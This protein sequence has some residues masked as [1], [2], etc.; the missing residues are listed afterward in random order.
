MNNNLKNATQEIK[1]I[2][3]RYNLSDTETEIILINIIKEDAINEFT[4]E[5]HKAL[6]KIQ[7]KNIT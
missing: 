4:Q 1:E 7:H 2:V 5:M 6:G 3:K